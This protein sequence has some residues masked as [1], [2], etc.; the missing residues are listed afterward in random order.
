MYFLHYFICQA[1]MYWVLHYDYSR[2][3]RLTSHFSSIKLNVKNHPHFFQIRTCQ[4]KVDIFS[5]IIKQILSTF[6]FISD[7]DIFKCILVKYKYKNYIYFVLK[8]TN[9]NIGIILIIFHFTSKILIK[10][11]T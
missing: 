8:F 1:E 3:F 9:K 2:A 11:F 7:S 4:G 6:F 5:T 10:K